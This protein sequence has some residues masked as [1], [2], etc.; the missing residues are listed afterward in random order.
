MRAQDGG[1]EGYALVAAVA[2]IL[3]FSLVALLVIESSRR[4]VDRN[5]AE[6]GRARAE[7]A[8]DAG[9]AMA[10]SGLSG[11]LAET[12]F[13]P[14]SRAVRLRFDQADL[15]IR[16]DD[17]Q[18]KVPLNALEEDQ[19]RRLLEK[20]GLSG[21]RLDIATDS[22]LDWTDDD[23]DVRPNGAEVDY[24]ARL[25]IRPRNGRLK[26][27]TELA[28]VR[29]I[30][31]VLADRLSDVATVHF[32]KGTFR[33]D[34]ATPLAIEI[35]NADEGAVDVINRARELAG[36]RTALSTEVNDLPLG[37][38]LTVHVTARLA[39]GSQAMVRQ[40]VVATGRPS[41]PFEL[42]ERY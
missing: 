41:H 3:I 28:L 26:S 4:L 10:L 34:R 30:G 32:G 5:G 37:K 33:A 40:M 15:A 9:V 11:G 17:E 21:D 25:G 36:Q 16:I 31:P 29:G 22:L 14:D 6:L 1:E 23:E 42:L 24:Y 18:G 39:D 38:T 19:T 8:A 12:R 20:M 2:G 27:L 13:R 35:M 7:A